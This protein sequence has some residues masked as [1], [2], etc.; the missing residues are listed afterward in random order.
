METAH[1]P[2]VVNPLVVITSKAHVARMRAHRILLENNYHP[3]IMVVDNVEQRLR[4]MNEAGVPHRN[5]VHTDRPTDLPPQDG[6]AWTRQW[7]EEHLV[8]R[9]QWYVTLDD[10]VGGWTWLPDPFN[11][12]SNIDFDVAPHSIRFP[13]LEPGKGF[14]QY[15]SEETTWRKLFD[16]PC[17]FE[18]VV[19]QWKALIE[20][21]ET[22]GTIAGGF[23]IETNFFFRGRKWQELGYVRAQNGVWKNVGL[24]FYYWPGAML[25]DFVRSVDAVARYGSIVINRFVKPQKQ[26]FEAGG[27]GSFE[28]RRPNL[29][30]CCQEIQRRWPGLTKEVKGRD[31][32]LT[33]ALRGKRLHE[34]RQKHGYLVSTNT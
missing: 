20:K 2:A 23:A 34:W 25:E 19:Q 30:A 26:F 27:I 11:R 32:S 13:Y 9:N 29:V 33:F 4:A 3:W 14:G 12:M 1:G 28:E 7:I 15:Q 24:P 31:Y 6:I 16:T 21:C 18:E 17:P 10:N 5:L 8:P 22:V